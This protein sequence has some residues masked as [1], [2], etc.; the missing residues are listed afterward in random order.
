M[1][2]YDNCYSP[3]INDFHW[4]RGYYGHSGL[5]GF[6]LQQVHQIVNLSQVSHCR[7]L[8]PR[9][10]GII[11]IIPICLGTFMKEHDSYISLL[12]LYLISWSKVENRNNKHLED[13]GTHHAINTNIPPKNPHITALSRPAGCR[14][15][16]ETSRFISAK[17]K[18]FLRPACSHCKMVP[19]SYKLVY[20]P[21]NY[22]YILY[23]S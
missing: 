15:S 2:F 16:P 8:S 20:N 7:G 22:R 23:L 1:T 4:P 19:P 11:M 21:I 13:V 9:S 18:L 12:W 5:V 14:M 17:R 6:C 3:A 10:P